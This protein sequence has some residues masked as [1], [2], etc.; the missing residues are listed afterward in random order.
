[1]LGWAIALS[2]TALAV[3]A[4]VLAHRKGTRR[5]EAELSR[6]VRG[7]AAEFRATGMLP[8]RPRPPRPRVVVRDDAVTVK[9]R[10]RRAQ[11]LEWSRLAEVAV[12]TTP[13]GPWQ[14][15]VFFLL[16][17]DA[18]SGIVVPHLEAA[19]LLPYLQ[20]LPGFD[21]GALIEAMGSAEDA[22]FVCWRRG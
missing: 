6:I 9:V 10:G 11:R 5:F 16:G 3:V 1:M 13:N 22:N 21:N 17:D 12:R 4:F 2:L 18:G 8:E 7:S 15:D 19:D 14:E 20:R